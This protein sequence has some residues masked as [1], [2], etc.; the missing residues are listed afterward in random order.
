VDDT[1]YR[2]TRARIRKALRL[3][4][5]LAL[6][7]PG[8]ALLG[9]FAAY[10]NG[11]RTPWLGLSPLQTISERARSPG[12]LAD[13]YR[14]RHTLDAEDYDLAPNF[15]PDSLSVAKSRRPVLAEQA[16]AVGVI[17]RF[18]SRRRWRP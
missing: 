17:H 13:R 15:A 14:D 12:A 18:T 4:L 2:K 7:V 16:G 6:F 11:E 10:G 8:F 5:M 1:D 9:A 3:A